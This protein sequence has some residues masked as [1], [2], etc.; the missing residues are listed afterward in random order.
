MPQDK[1][2]SQQ[3]ERDRKEDR[4]GDLPAHEGAST[5]FTRMDLDPLPNRTLDDHRRDCASLM[6]VKSFDATAA[7][8]RNV[9]LH[10]HKRFERDIALGAWKRRWAV[11]S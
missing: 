8:V 2:T 11:L 9:V 1:V 6:D 7:D 4:R 5:R 10:N 3:M